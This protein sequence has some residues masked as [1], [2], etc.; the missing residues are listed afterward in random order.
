MSHAERIAEFLNADPSVR[1]KRT[2]ELAVEVSRTERR[3]RLL[4]R[5][6]GL[7]GSAH[8]TVVARALASEAQRIRERR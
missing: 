3:A 8:W 6:Y 1:V 2:A 4:A 5:G 7:Q